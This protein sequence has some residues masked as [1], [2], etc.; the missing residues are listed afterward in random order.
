MS[1]LIDWFFEWPERVS[2][3]IAWL[4]PL[5]ARVI[6]GWEFLWSGWGK[7]QNLPAIADNF[8]GWHIPAAGLLVGGDV[9]TGIGDLAALRIA[10]AE[11]RR[12]P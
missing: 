9:S 11:A 4:A 12:T 5:F 7:L 6:V 2:Q 8:V 3:H 1:T 10:V